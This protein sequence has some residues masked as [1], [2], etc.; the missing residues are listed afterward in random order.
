MDKGALMY[1]ALHTPD[2]HVQA[3][4]HHQPKLR[5]QAVALLDGEPPLETVYATNKWARVLGVEKSM[6]RLQ[7]E[8]FT[9]AVVLHRNQGCEETGLSIIHTAAC[10]FSPRIE[11]V[12]AHPGT[13]VLDIQGMNSLFGDAAQLADKLR[14]R[15]MAAGF[16]ANVAVSQNFHAACCLARGRAGVSIVPPENEAQALGTLPLHVLDLEPEQADTFASWGI[17]TLAELATLPEIDLIARL[18]QVGKRLHSLARGEWP[19][20]M[21]PLEASFESALIEKFELDF[22]VE[23]LEPLLFLL[24][25]MIDQLLTRV[26]S[27]SLAIASLRI[28]LKLEPDAEGQFQTHQR[29]VRP[30][31]PLQDARTLL[32]LVQL[33]LE[34]HPPKAAIAA[35]ELSAQS[36]KPHRAQHGLFLPQSPEPGHLEVLLARLRKLLGDE[37]VGSPELLDDNRPDAFRMN[38]FS[39]P[40]PKPLQ[41]YSASTPAALRIYRPPQPIGVS[42]NGSL[43]IQVFWNGRRYIVAELAGPWRLSGQWWSESNWNREEWDVRLACGRT[44]QT[45]RIARDPSSNCWYVQG[46]Y[47]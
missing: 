31:M 21:I 2:F 18:G 11:A 40:S 38:P 27:H 14:Q 12:E 24:A 15:I 39:S 33:D 42:L 35:L 26:L 22:P 6:S 32:K 23:M 45:C 5:K 43:P 9:G 19:H 20:L 1:A 44:E 10:Y 16:L 36:A 46:T 30:A 17:R 8:S 41:Q 7:A 29:V 4:A 34:A 13:Y 37:R 47:D 25:R 28:I 3:V